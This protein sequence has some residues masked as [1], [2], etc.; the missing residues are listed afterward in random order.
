MRGQGLAGLVAAGVFGCLVSGCSGGSDAGSEGGAA[1]AECEA[2]SLATLDDASHRAAMYAIE[3][4]K[5]ESEVVADVRVDYLQIPALVQ[6]TGSGQYDVLSTSLSGLI[7]AREAS[8]QD[9]RIVGFGGAHTGPRL[10]AR[11]HPRRGR[12]C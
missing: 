10:P 6:A 11:G 3:T 2:I 1:G 4:G 9:L 5:V 12:G 7:L 8:G